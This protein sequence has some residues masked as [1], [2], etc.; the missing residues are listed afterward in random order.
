MKKGFGLCTMTTKI[1]NSPKFKLSTISLFLKDHVSKISQLGTTSS[2]QVQKYLDKLY[3]LVTGYEEIILD[4]DGTILTWNKDFEKMEGYSESEI[5]G[6]NINLFYLPQHRQL[7]MTESLIGSASTRGTATQF[8]QFVRKD[9]STF[10]G[11]IKMVA[12]KM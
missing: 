3:R 9:G 10:F 1:W 6:Q 5:L 4:N 12:V 7:K 2:A 8:G 11:S